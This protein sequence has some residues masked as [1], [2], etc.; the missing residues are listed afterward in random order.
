VKRLASKVFSLAV[1]AAAVTIVS[2]IIAP[3]AATDS[4]SPPSARPQVAV[5]R[6]VQ[7]N[8]AAPVSYTPGIPQPN[9]TTVVGTGN[10]TPSY[11]SGSRA[12]GYNIND[13][14]A[15]AEDLTAD[16][17]GNLL[18]WDGKSIS[19]DPA[20]SGEIYGHA[21]TAGRIYQIAGDETGHGQLGD[22][23]PAASAILGGGGGLA[24]DP[25]GNIL[26]ANGAIYVI[27]ESTTNPG[28]VLGNDC[29][30]GSCIWTP[31]DIFSLTTA[32]AISSGD[33][34]P[35]QSAQT[36]STSVAA[37]TNANIL[38]GNLSNGQYSNSEA[39]VR[40][41]AVGANP[42]YQCSPSCSTWTNGYIYTIAGNDGHCS[43]G[44]GQSALT[45]G[46]EHVFGL[47][48]DHEGNLLID[49][50]DG[51]GSCNGQ[52]ESAI[53][54]VALS[55]SN[56]GYQCSPSCAGSN[57]TIGDIYTI[58]GG[59]TDGYGGDG[60]PSTSATLYAPDA[61]A[62]DAA[63]NV[64]DA[65][66]AN[67]RV[68]V[69][70]V[71]SNTAYGLAMTGGD[72]YTVTGNGTEGFT[73]G[74][75]QQ[76]E[77]YGVTG[78]ATTPTGQLVLFDENNDRIREVGDGPPSLIGVTPQ[79]GSN[80]SSS[81]G[82]GSPNGAKCTCAVGEPINV[83]TG[84]FYDTHTD[85]RIPGAGVPLGFTRTYDA[86]V[87]QEGI[88][89]AGMGPGWTSNF[90]MNVSNTSGA[91]FAQLYDA[92]GNLDTYP[93]IGSAVVT[94][95][96]GAQDT[97]NEYAQ[98]TSPIPGWCPPDASGP[99][100]CPNAPR[101]SASL[102]QS[103]SCA[104]GAAWQLVRQV[105]NPVTFCFNAS[106]SLIQIADQNNDTLTEAP[107]SPGSGQQACPG[108]DTCTAWTSSVSGRSL[109][110]AVNASSQLVEVFDAATGG[111]AASLGYSG[112]GPAE[113]CSITDPGM[114]TSTTFAYYAGTYNMETMAPADGATVTN[115]YNASGQISEQSIAGQT[116]QTTDYS[117]ASNSSLPNG[118]TTTVTTYPNG[119][120]GPGSTT[121]T[122]QSSNDV[123][124]SE[125]DGAGGTTY[126]DPDSASLLPLA[127][128]DADGNASSTGL[129]DY[130]GPNGTA[131]SSAN[132]VSSTDAQGNTAETQFTTFNQPWCHFDAADEF[133][134]VEN[135]LTDRCA[136]TEPTVPPG[137]GTG[138]STSYLG[139]TI[140]YY[141]QYGHVIASTNPL[142]YTSV[143]AYT[144]QGLPYC[145]VDAFEY[146]TKGITCPT[147]PPTTAPTGTATG[148]TTK[149]YAPDGDLL[150]TTN[151]DGGTT[152][153]C[154]FWESGSGQCAAGAS[155][156]TPEELY[157]TTDL[158]D[159]KTTSYAYNAAGQVTRSVE[160][161][162]TSLATTIKGY[163]ADGRL[164]CMIA[165]LGYA[166]GHTSC[167]SPPS[168]APTSGSDPWPG[169]SI[170]IY[171][172]EGQVADEVN[173][174]GGV[175]QYAYDGQGNKYCT[176]KPSA[177][178]QGTTCPALPL[179]TPTPGN[180][181]DLYLGVTID[182]FDGDGRVVQETNPLGG[183]VLTQYDPA[184]NVVQTTTESNDGTNDP[185]VVTAT[186]Y[187]Q[188]NR[189]VS[190]TTDPGGSLSATT[191]QAYDPN[192]NT[193]CSESANAT[194][195]L[196]NGCQ[197][198]VWQP[199]W[200]TVPP[201][202]TTEYPSPAN[203]V[204]LSFTD[205]DGNQVQST[206]PDVHT[207]LTAYDADGRPYCT[208]DAT[209]DA[210][211][212]TC[213]APGASHV[214]GTVTT[215]FDPAGRTVS[216]TDQLGD[217]TSTVF[218]PNGNKLSTINPDGATTTNCYGYEMG[219]GQCAAA[220]TGGSWSSATNL[221]GTTAIVATSCATMVFCA[222]LDAGT[223]AYIDN[224]GAW[225]LTPTLLDSGATGT[226]LSCAPAT[227]CMAGDSSGKVF[228]YNGTSWSAATTLDTAVAIASIACTTTALC[229][230][231]DANGKAF[232][233]NGTSWSAATA[234]DAGKSIQSATCTQAPLCA[235]GDSSGKVFTY[236][237]T[238]WSS[239]TTLDSGYPIDT[240]SCFKAT[241][242]VAGDSRGRA[243]AFNGTSWSTAAILQGGYAISSVSC[244]SASLCVAVNAYGRAWT[245]N[246]SA[247]S[248]A[249]ILDSGI[250][251]NAVAC[252]TATR[253]AAVDASGNAFTYNG[254]S[255][256]SKFALD[257]PNSL[258]TVSCGA[259]T[260]CVA[261]DGSGN[262][263]SLHSSTWLPPVG[264]D[265]SNQLKAVS[266]AAADRCTAVDNA[267]NA[268]SLGTGSW[269]S[270]NIDATTSL[271]SVSCPTVGFCAAGDV[272]GKVL[273]YNGSS[274][275]AATVDSG[276]NIASVSCTSASFCAA[277]DSAGKVA[278][279]NGS[280]W[281]SLTTLH[282]SSTITS[283]SC[284]TSTFCVA[285]NSGGLAWTYTSSGWSSSSATVASGISLS[286]S[287][288]STTL[289]LA[290]GSN[291]DI[292]TSYN[293][294]SW[295]AGMPVDSG[296]KINSVSCS[297]T[298]WCEAVDN[299]G[300]VYTDKGSSWTNATSTDG[301]TSLADVSCVS[302]S[303]CTA[304]DGSSAKV[305][306]QEGS[307]GA[308]D[309]FATQTP[310]TA[311]DPSGTVTTSTDYPDGS[312]DAKL[313]PAGL[314]TDD[315]D[316]AGDLTATAYADQAPGYGAVSPTTTSYNQDGSRAQ[317]VDGTGTTTYAYDD[318]GD[319]TS[320]AFVYGPMTGLSSQTLGYA[321]FATGVLQ[322]LTYPS[323]T[324]Y[325]NPAATYTYDGTG[326]M[327]TVSDWAGN[328][329]TFVHDADNN[330][331]TQENAT[332]SLHPSGTSSTAWTYDAADQIT[333]ASATS[334]PIINGLTPS[335]GTASSAATVSSILGPTS[336]YTAGSGCTGTG[337]TVSQSFTGSTGG[338]NA[339]GQLTSDTLKVADGCSTPDTAT[340]AH[341]YSYDQAGRVVY[342]GNVAQGASAANFGYDAAGN[343][344]TMSGTDSSGHFDTYT[345]SADS[346]GEALSQTPIAGSG[347]LSSIDTYDTLGDRTTN[348]SGSTTLDYG[349]DQLGNM[350]SY[351]AGSNS[352]S[353]TYSGDGLEISDKPPGASSPTQ[354]LWNTSPSLPLLVSNGTFY[355]VYGPG[356]TPVEQFDTAVSPPAS[357]PTFLNYTPGDSYYVETNPSGQLTNLYGY[358]AFG[359]LISGQA[360]G[361][362]F[363][364]AGQYADTSSNSAGFT[365]MR[366]RWYDST[367]GSFTR[368]DP[369]LAQTNQAYVY[370]GDDPVNET[371]PSG[372]NAIVNGGVDAILCELDPEE[373][374]AEGP[375]LPLPIPFP[376]WPWSSSVPPSNS[377]LNPGDQWVVRGGLNDE[378]RWINGSQNKQLVFGNLVDVSVNSAPG[379]TIQELSAD[380][381]NKQ[382]S[383]STR[384]AVT[385]AGGQVLPK[386]LPGR[387]LH[388]S[389]NGI[390][391]AT[392]VSIFTQM[393]NPNQPVS[394]LS[395]TSTTN[396][397]NTQLTTT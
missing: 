48:P 379:A 302:G 6:T 54:M 250:A 269:A 104:T 240:V 359:S 204:T 62:V 394:L 249:T 280:S 116:T 68:R 391:P 149:I 88:N 211:G 216:S 200:I 362:P 242:C 384:S 335:G 290:G 256:S 2:G 113:V 122:Y 128:V 21:M 247:W 79:G 324:S 167:P 220:V 55:S 90:S 378:Q 25:E 296:G 77:V 306:L 70:A 17:Q 185:N 65:E 165:P 360:P 89:D 105:T 92:N 183:I 146:S 41:I 191:E 66:W 196:P 182:Q 376:S 295:S 64:I 265:G 35:A 22:G 101:I 222:A 5:P 352:T 282:A 263:F 137:A 231:G 82:G 45:A 345:Q 109:V 277:G 31:G 349:Y 371:D 230:A 273:A 208:V 199:G 287:C 332:S 321:Y 214:T 366:A 3:L 304:V 114:P 209:N 284:V 207:T 150:S 381:P 223:K 206:N 179:T 124:V 323:L 331:A 20:V 71:K 178:A 189:A 262:V 37:D 29:A 385:G 129:Q 213:P 392:A 327:A 7:L 11:Q 370:A 78:V 36:N 330:P 50:Y 83:S 142:G 311:A 374:L 8:G 106:G 190:T 186:S 76:A 292:Y 1:A 357:N 218:D 46:I 261:G 294:S 13:P 275:P 139:A 387:P 308:S 305:L 121:A 283:I 43:A 229:V 350:T 367:T 132:A 180:G 257:L 23:I 293:G 270:A 386:P 264:I 388:A 32:N 148:Y 74:P 157:S 246:G 187:D 38:L 73:T 358:D 160:T 377:T 40:V 193:Y 319:M 232:T 175:T 235:V 173:P 201:N 95:E 27:A 192:G 86:S 307:V 224:N 87:A 286:V 158:P 217:V 278:T 268:L 205:A 299:T 19:V 159:G 80:A 168:G 340:L 365:N 316:A 53:R 237:G 120:S 184:G 127:T 226:A 126:A 94:D 15:N 56:P 49:D 373:C 215:T 98:S 326:Q 99:V 252:P 12:L 260:T 107:Y 47:V 63:G 337:I 234:L 390:T 297:S 300:D 364:Y 154:Y 243:S 171:N 361:S 72:I 28:Y 375:P 16:R 91:G 271:S 52:R 233:Y 338:R 118:V 57:W 285:V 176:V 219:P 133:N 227:F 163:D 339:D 112:C 351:T 255:W 225:S 67:E 166:E 75:A 383:V 291:G 61:I 251:I 356:G 170:T 228:S 289:C 363:S 202:P 397:T 153:N 131:T 236:N 26:S 59:H 161:F 123:L 354:L 245:Y 203:G 347:G 103:T 309:L 341:D 372:D 281:S 221:A 396:C 188:D 195:E 84:D 389:L 248:A 317:M 169:A 130:N 288:P 320:Q 177:Y 58:A 212:I 117:Y 174:L 141:D 143:T 325:T 138:V 110:L 125:T 279:Y 115:T 33:G 24:V 368:P 315:Y 393:G 342:E 93:T 162:G 355:F 254:T 272:S 380:L 353:Y 136:L 60:G 102:T 30:G 147:T 4:F 382:I 18:F 253:C 312:P 266:C 258:K 329:I 69:I 314:T 34:G 274:W 210:A 303:L 310:P 318:N 96:N 140:T 111:Q 322:K 81:T 197:A 85:L 334:G 164:Y 152:A 238:S 119:K 172:G 155:G 10:Q 198:V 259:P 9:I 44:D 241:L 298:T 181:N 39:S 239:A 395:Y 108:G 14:I 42:G 51:S 343:A 134:V 328:S 344:T 346:A 244:A 348:T 301:A 100:F 151:P 144:A 156:G 276:K 145:T 194:A 267:G 313:T 369:M 97:F 135:N 333:G 336:T